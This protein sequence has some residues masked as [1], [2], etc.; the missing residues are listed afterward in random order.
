[1]DL[2]GVYKSA[3]NWGGTTLYH[4]WLHIGILWVLLDIYIYTYIYMHIHNYSQLIIEMVIAVIATDLSF[5]E[6]G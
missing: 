1:M 2:N 4:L 6:M 3:Y 5:L